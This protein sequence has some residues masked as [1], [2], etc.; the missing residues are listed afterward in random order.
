MS[1]PQSLCCGIREIFILSYGRGRGFHAL[2]R[3]SGWLHAACSFRMKGEYHYKKSGD[4]SV[5]RMK[6]WHSMNCAIRLGFHGGQ[7]RGMRNMVLWEPQDE[8]HADICCM[9]CKCRLRSRRFISFRN[10]DFRWKKSERWWCY[11]S[12]SCGNGLRHSGSYGTRI[13][14]KTQWCQ[15]N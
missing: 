4:M 8:T 6:S 1:K 7:F 11:Q 3:K 15:I 14:P 10:L 13:F 9:I 5:W 12:R 2:I